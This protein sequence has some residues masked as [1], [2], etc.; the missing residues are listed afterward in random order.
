MI[1]DANSI[2]VITSSQ[3]GHIHISRIPRHSLP[4]HNSWPSPPTTT[5]LRHVNPSH[6]SP[7][8]NSPWSHTLIS[9]PLPP[10]L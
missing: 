1:D 10:T 2:V 4:I 5:S 9:P 3:E 7:T 8:P 6:W